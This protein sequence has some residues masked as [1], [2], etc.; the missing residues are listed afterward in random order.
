M[1]ALLS[2]TALALPS[3]LDCLTPGL[4]AIT[5]ELPSLSATLV[6]IGAN[7]GFYTMLF[8]HAGFR[9]VALEPLAHNRR[10][11]EANLCL[12]PEIA[13]RARVNIWEYLASSAM[14]FVALCRT[15]PSR[16]K[17]SLVAISTKFF[18]ALRRASPS[19]KNSYTLRSPMGFALR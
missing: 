7:L 1:L 13:K 17:S 11:L 12:N 15:L 8:A 5:S 16:K 18:V 14:L 4:R 9:V 2:L 19:R 10:A 3:A 6:D